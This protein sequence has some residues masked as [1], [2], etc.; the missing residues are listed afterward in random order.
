MEL[1]RRLYGTSMLDLDFKY[2]SVRINTV[3]RK[4]GPRI[5]L[6]DDK[7][8]RRRKARAVTAELFRM[9]IKRN[10]GKPR[11]PTSQTLEKRRRLY[12]ERKQS[13]RVADRIGDEEHNLLQVLGT[14]PGRKSFPALSKLCPDPVKDAV[15]DAT[16]DLV[17]HAARSV[18]P[19][20][21]RILGRKL[22]SR[23]T[24][25]LFNMP[26]KTVQ[27]IFARSR[28]SS[29]ST[30]NLSYP[31]NVTREKQNEAE[32]KI[33]INF[34]QARCAYS[35]SA[36]RES[37]ALTLRTTYKAMEQEFYAQY[38]ALLKA[39]C[40]E[41]P[42]LLSN[43]KRQSVPTRFEQAILTVND[44]KYVYSYQDRLASAHKKYQQKLRS[45]APV[46]RSRSCQI[47]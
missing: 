34:F 30:F 2:D 33:C 41:D 45:C 31:P 46:E 9:G 4:P 14:V 24:A 1:E 20:L 25:Q 21:V 18:K 11:G 5:R 10:R 28:Q 26:L 12:V 3:K 43:A 23:E 7:N 8:V 15:V 22:K 37:A 17:Q 27:N 38:P 19:D 35:S 39:A 13:K 16:V 47:N 29:I 36:A 40:A 42:Q 6:Y 44:P 32:A